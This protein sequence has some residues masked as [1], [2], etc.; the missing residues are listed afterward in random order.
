MIN[1]DKEYTEALE[2]L[3][4]L[5][6]CSEDSKEY[7]ESVKLSEDVLIYE[8]TKSKSYEG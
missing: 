8:N 5:K 1:N 7:H 2:R 4:T 3:K 6:S